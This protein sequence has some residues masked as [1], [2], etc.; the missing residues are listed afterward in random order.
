MAWLFSSFG[1][2]GLPMWAAIVMFVVIVGTFVVVV[3]KG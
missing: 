3:V 2:T 1:S